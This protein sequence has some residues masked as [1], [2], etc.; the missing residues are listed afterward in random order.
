MKV[1]IGLDIGTTSTKAVVFDYSG[2]VV[3]EHAV[4]YPILSNAPNE[5]EQD[6]DQIFTAVIE[7]TRYALVK[8]NVML[9]D[10]TAVGMSAAMH[11]IMAVGLEGVP[12]T[13]LIIWADNRSASQARRILE[14]EDGNEIYHRTGTPIHAMSPL[15]KLF[16]L[17][18]NEPDIFN[19]AV[20]FISIKEYVVY[21]LFGQYIVDHSIASATGLFNLRELDWDEDVLRVLEIQRTQLSELKTTTHILTGINEK[22]ALQMGLSTQVPFVLGASDGVLANLGVGA[23]DEGEIA[24]TIGTS[25]AVRTVTNQPITDEK[26][27]TFCYVLTDRQWVVGGATNNGAIVLDWLRNLFYPNEH[28]SDNGKLLDL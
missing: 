3:A 25:G 23:I 12:L 24:V 9:K 15:S 11:S 6:P 19:K 16:W 26:Q 13:R 18:E 28:Q 17:K 21:R 22:Y 20:K 7:S 8:A 27:R 2:K 4:P 1:I 14:T 5:A 10:I